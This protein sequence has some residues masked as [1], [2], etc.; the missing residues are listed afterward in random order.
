MPTGII[1][2]DETSSPVHGCT[3]AGR[4]CD[5]CYARAW[6]RR[7]AGMGV[8]GY[9]KQAPFMV[10]F[11]PAQLDKLRRW[12]L[13]RT[14]LMCAMGDMF[15]ERVRDEWV[16]QIFTAIRDTPRHTYL[17]LTKRATRMADYVLKFQSD[18]FP[19][20]VFFGVSG[21]D[22]ASVDERLGAVAH[23]AERR[24]VKTWLSLEP[25]LEGVEL[26]AHLKRL[27]SVVVGGESGPKARPCHIAWIRR[28]VVQCRLAEVPVCVKQLGAKLWETA[29]GTSPH[30]DRPLDLDSGSGGNPD[31]WPE[32]LRVRET[33]W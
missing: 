15:H 31:E 11:M 8:K 12:R 1:Y 9:S 22:Q 33:A 20:N 26:S 10:R 2:C 13:P 7:L 23:L 16:H 14:V 29:T 18:P 6:S 4:G 17:L 32:D 24:G 19:A 25:L 27:D 28:V 30:Y 21:E 5:H 3:S